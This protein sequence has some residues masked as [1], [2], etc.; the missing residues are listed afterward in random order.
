MLVTLVVWLVFAVC[1]PVLA[2][3]LNEISIPYLDLPLGFFLA[4]Q[5]ALLAFLLVLH[6]FTR[7]QDCIDRD[8]FLS[9]E[10][11]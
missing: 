2:V 10:R 5:G 11:V 7:R 6:I 4:T 8:H 1:A 9:D 3:L